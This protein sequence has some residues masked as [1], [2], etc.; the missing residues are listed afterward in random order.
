M[1]TPLPSTG[2]LVA[3]RR[4]LALIRQRPGIDRETIS[5]EVG[6]NRSYTK[7]CLAALLGAG[8]IQATL[9]LHDGRRRAYYVA[10]GS[11]KTPAPLD[12]VGGDAL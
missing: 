12:P 2:F 4:I 11:P 3:Q 10:D 1:T 6:L 8:R 5:G 7:K 9:P